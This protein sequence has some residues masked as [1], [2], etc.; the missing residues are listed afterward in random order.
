MRKRTAA[1]TAATTSLVLA[2]AACGGGGG[3]EAAESEA[4]AEVAGNITVLTNRTDLVDTVFADYK[5]DFEAK[6]PDVNVTFEAITD[7]E[8]EVATRMS[9][10]DYGDVLL[11]P[12]SVPPADLPDFFEPLGTPEELSETYRFTTAEQVYEGQV[13]GLAIT[14]NAQGYVYNKAVWEDAG[15]AEAPTS[16]EEFL[17]ALRAISEK[18]DAIPLYTN[19]ADGWPLTQFEGFRG[20]ITGDPEAANNLAHLDAPWGEG[21]EHFVI[22]SLLFSAAEEGLIEPDPTTTNWEQ[23]KAD[24]AAGKI[25]SMFLGSW[26]IVQMQEAAGGEDVIGYRPFPHQVDGTFYS[27]IGGDYK[28]GINVNSK[29]KAA[30]RAWVTWFADESGYATD[31]GG[32]APRLDGE[33]PTTLSEFDELGVEYV[34]LAPAPEGEEGL[35]N[36]IDNQSEIGLWSPDYRRRIVDAARGASGE[37]KVQVF[38]DLNGRWAEARASV[39]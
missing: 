16:P 19:Y 17:D 18:T 23:S 38:D 21:E 28:N 32:I 6:Y 25:G 22:D 24:L 33:T 7:Y 10:A 27:T 35:V 20:T 5:A 37:T 4:D 8:G 9:T 1:T 15:I 11:I 26:A 12:N 39:N 30:A 31:Q 29:N 3:S 13:Y 14:G 34:E 2:L 36:E